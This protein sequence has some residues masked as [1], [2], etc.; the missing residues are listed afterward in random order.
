MKLKKDDLTR[1]FNE[2]V[3]SDIEFNISLDLVKQNSNP[4]K[5]W[6]IGGYIYRNLANLLYGTACKPA[7][8][9]DFI[10][11]NHRKVRNLPKGWRK[12]RN[13]F[14]G[15]KFINAGLGIEID[16]V[17]LDKLYVVVKNG[18]SPTIESYLETAPLNIQSIAYE[19]PEGE[20]LGRIVGDVGIKG[21]EDKV[22]CVNDLEFANDC[23]GIY[24]TTVNNQIRRKAQEL[25]FRPVYV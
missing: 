14:K 2:I 13:T 24:K 11:E 23:A 10:V 4:G 12:A 25:G 20:S 18:V 3:V 19:I 17:G 8:D 5:I 21:L 6:L 16:Y 15:W 1:A 9:Y 7:K 22:V